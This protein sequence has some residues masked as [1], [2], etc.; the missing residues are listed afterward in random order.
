LSPP[1][2]LLPL[3]PL[4]PSSIVIVVVGTIAELVVV[5]SVVVVVVVGGSLPLQRSVLQVWQP[6]WQVKL[7]P[8][9]SV[10]NSG[11]ITS[12]KLFTAQLR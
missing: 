1:S 9:A 6:R 12:H 5:S 3:S 2:L 4:L 8:R 10:V 7:L 11:I